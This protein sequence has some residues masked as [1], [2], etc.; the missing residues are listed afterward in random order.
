MKKK[1]LKLKVK[2]LL[3]FL[4]TIC[5]VSLC[6]CIYVK[7]CFKPVDKNST[8]EI[9]FTVKEG[10][11]GITVLNNLKDKDLIK[12]PF[13]G[14]LYLKSHSFD[15]KIGTH[16][17]KKSQSFKEI[18]KT[19]EKEKP[20]A[21][22]TIVEGKRLTYIADEISKKFDYSSEEVLN[23]M[24]DK[25]YVKTLISKYSFLT[26]DILKDGIYHPLEGYL[27]PETYSFKSDESIKSIIET[28]LDTTEKKTAN[29][30]FSKSTYTV[31]QIFTLASIIEL[32]GSAASDR[33]GIA[34][35]FYN[36]LNQNIS[37]GSDVTTYYGAKKDFSSDLTVTD[38]NTCNPYN[39]RGNCNP[40]LPI[41]PIDSPSVKSIEA[42]LNPTPSDYLFFVADKDGKTY[43]SKTNAEHEQIVNKLKAEG[44]WYVYS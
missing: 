44:L 41:G 33:N 24:D 7:S 40:G 32:E 6:A 26:D 2:I 21:W 38:L 20:N 9:E 16:K 18:L 25:E 3:C 22:L 10:D 34:G 19:L 35:V 29:L 5:I 12:S 43:F 17:L 30:D 31:H 14:K 11:A 4:V 27:F 28:M 37:L 42:A 13:V 15:P 8:K 39:T 1:K 36:R 23:T